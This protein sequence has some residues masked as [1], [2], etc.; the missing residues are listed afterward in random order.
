MNKRIGFLIILTLLLLACQTV[1]RA[2]VLE[3]TGTHT[4]TP[5]H[6]ILPSYT[7]SPIP[8]FTS[9]S[10]PRQSTPTLPTLSPTATKVPSV[11]TPT[12]LPITLQLK[13]FEDL[14]NIVNEEYLYPDFN[15]LN[16]DAVY[17]E[18]LVRIQSGLNNQEFYQAME[19]MILRLGDDHSV[20]LNP[21]QVAKENAEFEGKYQYAGIGVLL[22]AVPELNRAV[23]LITFPGFPADLAGLKPRDAIL[24]VNGEPILNED[25]TLRDLLRGP[26]GTR[27]LITAQRPGGPIREISVMRTLISSSLPVPHQIFYSPGGKRIGYLLIISF[28]DTNIDDHIEE[29]LK[30]MT[31]DAPLDGLILDNTY[32][33]G[34]SNT[35]FKPVLS[36]FASGRLGDYVTRTSERPLTI[37]RGRDINGSQSVPLVILISKDTVSFGEIFAG[38]LQDIGRAYLIGETTNGNIEILWGYDFEDGSRAWIAHETFRPLNHPDANWEETGIVPDITLDVNWYEY[39]LE[40]DPRILAALE[41]FDRR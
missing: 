3:S 17:S 10:T 22:M 26:E 8:S 21:E 13:I 31:A 25:G 32:N 19:E 7:S 33:Q 11:P 23:V 18:Y 35:V 24:T 41:Y 4:P 1:N 39:K 20:F 9:T 29:A 6:T 15:G 16:W 36:F 5:S 12:Q 30:E 38:I 37:I 2:M 34:G 14:W 27:V 40:E 28:L